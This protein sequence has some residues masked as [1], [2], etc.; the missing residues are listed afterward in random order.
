MTP[1]ALDALVSLFGRP[2]AEPLIR[3][4]EE[5]GDALTGPAYAAVERS[6]V[7]SFTSRRDQRDLKARICASSRGSVGVG[8]AL[9]A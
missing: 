7:A 9:A 3:F 6:R 5:T 2:D 1:A 4:L 8:L